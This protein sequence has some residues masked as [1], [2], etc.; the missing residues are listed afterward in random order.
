MQ[1]HVFTR[2]ALV[3]ALLMLTGAL[4]PRSAPADEPKKPNILV[5]FGD[6]IGVWNISAY[7]RGMMGGRTPNIWQVGYEESLMLFHKIN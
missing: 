1:H 3:A 4:A 5:I 6:D 7:H 2:A